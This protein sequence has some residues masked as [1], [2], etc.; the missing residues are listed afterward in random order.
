MDHRF[1]Y[2]ITPHGFG[3]A[4]RSAAVMNALYR[5]FPEA[6]MEIY[7]LVP[8]WF[9]SEALDGKFNYHQL[10]TDVGLVQE[11][12]MVENLPATLNLLDE[13]FGE[14][15]ETSAKLAM[16]E[17]IQNSQAILA[18]VSALGIETAHKAGLP[19]F[20]VENFTW[21]WIY[22]I[23]TKEYPQFNSHIKRFEDIYCRTK[24][25]LQTEPLCE[26]KNQAELISLPV[27]REAREDRKNIRERLGINERE[28]MVLVTMGGIPTR[29]HFM[30]QLIGLKGVVFVIPGGSQTFMSRNNLRLL[31]H[32]SDFFHPDLVNASD[33]VI[34]K[35]GYSTTAEVWHTGAPFGYLSRQNFREA[36]V[37]GE[38]IQDKLHGIEFTDTDFESGH[39]RNLLFELLLAG[40]N[41]RPVNNGAAVIADFIKQ[42]L[43]I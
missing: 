43:I 27:C 42:K 8:E 30:E 23:Y 3:H 17:N 12:S 25:R 26:R 33:A 13:Y 36:P 16:Q 5:L 39:W 9:F 7:T 15:D 6:E 4:S 31:P 11:N 35:A 2:F 40:Q 41:K 1:T 28:K 10:R 32:H 38:F 29:F 37:L 34:A 24:Y 22:Q 19:S 18:D 14:F 20:L 21:D